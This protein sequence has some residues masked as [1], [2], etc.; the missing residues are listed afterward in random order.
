MAVVSVLR[1]VR[2]FNGPDFFCHLE[3]GAWVRQHRE[4]PS[5][6]PFDFTD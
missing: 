4:L 3:T 6:D 2:P 5:R 1:I